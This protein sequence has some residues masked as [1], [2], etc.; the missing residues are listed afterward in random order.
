[1]QTASS[2]MAMSVSKLLIAAYIDGTINSWFPKLMLGKVNENALL[3]LWQ[4]VS[5]FIQS[6]CM[7]G[8]LITM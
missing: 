1:M 3:F 7:H 8:T 5:V 4:A 6:G 2:A